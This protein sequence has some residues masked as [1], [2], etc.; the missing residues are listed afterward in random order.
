MDYDQFEQLA[1]SYIIE[2]IPSDWLLSN[3]G[4]YSELFKKH[5]DTDFVAADLLAKCEL[6]ENC[7]THLLPDF[8]KNNLDADS[9]LP[10][11]V[12]RLDELEEGLEVSVHN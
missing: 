6:L 2:I 10:R 3:A 5:L 9:L 4:E 1:I 8:E 11:L 12:D 7:Y